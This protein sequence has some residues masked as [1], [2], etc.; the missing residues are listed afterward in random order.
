M[1]LLI[2]VIGILFA[3]FFLFIGFKNENWPAL[4]LGFFT[5]ILVGL[6]MGNFGVDIQSGSLITESG[7]DLIVQ[8][9][10]ENYN[11][12]NNWLVNLIHLVFIGGGTI[13]ILLSI[14]TN[15]RSWL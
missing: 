6:M 4:Y 15:I 5:V 1:E 12:V 10:Y 8:K 14:I 11:I 2:Y 13:M 3:L 9:T 7:T